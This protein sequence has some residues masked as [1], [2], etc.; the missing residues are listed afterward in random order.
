MSVLLNGLFL[1]IYGSCNWISSQREDY[2][3]LYSNW[4]LSIPLIP[5]F[6]VLYFSFSLLTVVPIFFLFQPQITLLAKRM[7]LSIIISGCIF[8]FIPTQLG[9]TRIIENDRYELMFSLLHQIDYPH[10]LFPSLHITLS[11]ITVFGLIPYC[12]KAINYI[13]GTWWILLCVSVVMVHQH[14]IADIVGGIM[15]ASIT[16]M[17][18]KDRNKSVPTPT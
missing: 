4:E 9:F 11:T 13:L 2:W 6:I 17:V 18:L 15:I 12:T 5:E 7:A 8:L 3:R 1:I 10:N 16:M 14:H